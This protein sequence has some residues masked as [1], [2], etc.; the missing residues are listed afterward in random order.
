MYFCLSLSSLTKGNIQS[1]FNRESVEGFK[2][3]IINDML[4]FCPSLSYQ[5]ADLTRNQSYQLETPVS[6]LVL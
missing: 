3:H 2:V 5:N 4:M 6:Q 1:K